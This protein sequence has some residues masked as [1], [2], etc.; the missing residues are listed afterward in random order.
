MKRT[1]YSNRE[2]AHL[3]AHQAQAAAEGSHF[4]FEGDTIYSYGP[5]FPIARIVTVNGVQRVLF[6]T[7]SYS[8]TTAGHKSI[9]Y[10]ACCHLPVIEVHNVMADN[11]RQHLD[12]LAIMHKRRVVLEGKAK[13]ART[14]R[15]AYIGDIARLEANAARYMHMFLPD[16][17]SEGT[18]SIEQR[19]AAAEAQLAE[20]E[21]AR[22]ARLEAEQAK[23]ARKERRRFR[24]GEIN[25]ASGPVMLR[26]LEGGE[27]LTS[28]GARVSLNAGKRLY[29][30]ACEC[31]RGRTEA[32][33]GFGEGP[34]I[35]P[36]RLDS[37]DK[38]GNVKIGCHNIKFRVMHELAKEL[39]IAQSF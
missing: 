38:Y 39:G 16:R 2:V 29:R 14:R 11:D 30:L 35:G 10:S 15:D 13:R 3:W 33:Y 36:Y 25:Y 1:G 8:V 5:H 6:T 21:E 18:E 24:A 28:Q 32:G 12:N 26:Q 37:I 22:R 31:K 19:L 7:D 4:Y 23:R 34:A 9:A 17:L 20:A 27:I